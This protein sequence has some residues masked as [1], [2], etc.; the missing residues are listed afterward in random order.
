MTEEWKMWEEHGHEGNV[1]E[2][3]V[4]DFFLKNSIFILVFLSNRLII[5]NE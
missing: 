5:I 2:D 1:L 4:D 3:E